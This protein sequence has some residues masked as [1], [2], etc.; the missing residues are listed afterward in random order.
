MASPR[1]LITVTEKLLGQVDFTFLISYLLTFNFF[2]N[3]TV[4]FDIISVNSLRFL[5]ISRWVC[6]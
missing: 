2:Y 6:F 4:A 5:I 1:V 3:I